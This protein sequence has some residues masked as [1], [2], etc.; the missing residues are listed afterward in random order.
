MAGPPGARW[1]WRGINTAFV[2]RGFPGRKERRVGGAAQR[3]GPPC[4]LWMPWGWEAGSRTSGL[5]AGGI[6][7]PRAGTGVRLLGQAP[8]ARRAAARCAATREGEGGA[9]GGWWGCGQRMAPPGEAFRGA[10][11]G[12]CGLAK[13]SR[14][15]L[16]AGPGMGMGRGEEVG[17]PFRGECVHEWGSGPG[18]LFRTTALWINGCYSS[19]LIGARSSSGCVGPP[20][21]E[22]GDIVSAQGGARGLHLKMCL[23]Q[24]SLH[25]F[26]GPRLC[27]PWFFL[28]R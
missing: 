23:A 3:S 11:D 9:R 12:S 25:F 15:D 5:Q 13:A 4:R 24:G 7:C 2:L 27:H 6:L 19:L 16:A 22:V 28:L 18:P 17:A 26:P 21:S 10:W 8:G 1:G 14:L 20:N